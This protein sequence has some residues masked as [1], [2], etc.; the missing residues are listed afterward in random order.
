MTAQVLHLVL[1]TGEKPIW[2]PR[3]RAELGRCQSCEWHPPTQGH[4]PWCPRGDDSGDNRRHVAPETGG[5]S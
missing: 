2:S 1:D 3:R 4:H 5:S